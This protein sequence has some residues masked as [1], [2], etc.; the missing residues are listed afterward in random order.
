MKNGFLKIAQAEN[1][2]RIFLGFSRGVLIKTLRLS[3][4]L[5][6]LVVWEPEKFSI[7]Q[8][9]NSSF[10]S[11]KHFQNMTNEHR[12]SCTLLHSEDA[13]QINVKQVRFF[14]RSHESNKNE[15]NISTKKWKI[16]LQMY[17][18]TQIFSV[19]YLILPNHAE[20]VKN[21]SPCICDLPYRIRPALVLLDKFLSHPWV[22]VPLVEPSHFETQNFF[23]D[24]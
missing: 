5:S 9:N 15:E 24:E 4:R 8:K 12:F 22:L 7:I 20:T 14:I 17:N 6:N 21:D 23:A 1:F 10:F 2:L 16:L 18:I 11:L 3:Y 13:L 19:N